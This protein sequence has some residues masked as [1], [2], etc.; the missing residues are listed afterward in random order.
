MNSGSGP[1]Q[2]LQHFGQQAIA[3]VL[4]FSDAR[5]GRLVM[6]AMLESDQRVGPVVHFLM[7]PLDGVDAPVDAMTPFRNLLAEP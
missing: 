5:L 7:Q 3:Q 1:S 4:D 2:Q 6:T